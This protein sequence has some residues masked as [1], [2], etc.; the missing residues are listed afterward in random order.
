MQKVTLNQPWGRPLPDGTLEALEGT[1]EVTDSQAEALIAAGFASP[2][3][4]KPA[5]TT[6]QDKAI[7]P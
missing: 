6:K 3:E 4:N 1:V 5:P 7:A 2:V